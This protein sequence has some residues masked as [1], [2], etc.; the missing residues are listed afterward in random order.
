MVFY[1]VNIYF[2]YYGTLNAIL[3]N[4][5]HLDVKND[6]INICEREIMNYAERRKRIIRTSIIGIAAN[7]MLAAFKAFVG[8]MSNSI[9]IMLDAVNNLSDVL[10]S[11][12]TIIG[13]KLAG[14]KPDK[15]HPLGHGRIEYISAMVIAMVILYAG[16]ASLFEAVK[17]I[18]DPGTPDYNKFTL[19]VVASAVIVK[20]VLGRYVK[21]VGERIE[22]EALAASGKDALYDAVISTATL[23]AA[24]IYIFFDISLEA[25]IA[26]AI[27]VFII[28]AGIDI[29][30]GTFS[31]I[32]GER[33]D[34]ELA[35]KI[36]KTI[37]EHEGVYGAYDLI[38][39][40][41][42]PEL[43]LG[44]V[45]IEISD[46]FTAAEIDELTR[47]IQEDI[48]EEYDV[49]LTAIG[50][51]SYNTKDDFAAQARTDI[52]ELVMSHDDIVQMHGFFLDEKTKR[53]SFDVIVGFSSK[54]REGLYKHICDDIKEKYPDYEL[55]VT[56]DSDISD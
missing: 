45:H 32:I 16:V 5:L 24:A 23:V 19:I 43:L 4:F 53:I 33:I 37:S 39:H 51:Y 8:F 36:K 3:K 7:I 6:I 13:A 9:A 29:L 11:V 38:L 41:Y 40:S 48:F 22:S 28:K 14:K 35:K 47:H 15:E 50:I 52:V 25:W 42:G 34:S 31:K 2:D 27:S 30:K 26:A 10:S 17:K 55:K 54:D 46:T 18:I 56:M 21:S 44:S 12:I 1:I 20:I 49:M